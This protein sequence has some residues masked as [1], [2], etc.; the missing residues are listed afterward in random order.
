MSDYRFAVLTYPPEYRRQRGPEIVALANELAGDRWSIRQWLGLVSG[1]LRA[2]ARS[3]TRSTSRGVWESGTR[4]A[5][6]IWLVIGAANPLTAL[7]QLPGAPKFHEEWYVLAMPLLLI[8]ALTISTRWWV[9]LLITVHVGWRMWVFASDM[10]QVTFG[11]GILV[12]N[13]LIIGIAWWLALATDGRR[14]AGIAPT[15]LLTVLLTLWWSAL[16]SNGSY[17]LAA[18][19]VAVLAVVAA[20]VV[21][22]SDPRIAAAIAIF[23]GITLTWDL[24]FALANDAVGFNY[25]GPLTFSVAFVIVPWL[26]ARS[27]IHRMVSA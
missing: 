2:R 25:W 24:P 3:A 4:I 23:A 19:L 16:L 21:A 13:V 20:L 27:G 14:A 9:A 1:G 17:T 5:L 6:L 22:T 26:A 7:L 18:N 10:P 12:S 15:M 11:G 8:A